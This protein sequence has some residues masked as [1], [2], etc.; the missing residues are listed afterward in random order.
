MPTSGARTFPL[1]VVTSAESAACDA[2]A[3]GAGIPSRALM[4]RAAAAAASEIALRYRDRL[5]DG[6]L[7]IAGPGNNGG[8]AWVVARAL[9]TAGVP[10][11]VI[12]PVPAKTPDAIAER[13]LTIES[14]GSQALSDIARGLA[15]GESIVVDGLLGTGSTGAPRG[16][17]ADAVALICSAREHGR[18]I[19]AL[20]VPTGIDATTGRAAGAF[21]TADLTLTFGTVKRGQLV[22]REACGTIVVLDIGL[23]SHTGAARGSP[24][25]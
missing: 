7:I 9:A 15:G 3:I 5:G 12:E 22:N 11:R 16:P 24:S 19:V 2:S 10:V 25:L 6:V 1:R 23:G 14:V 17:I 18:T 20:D 13:S 8:D 4:Q 21:V